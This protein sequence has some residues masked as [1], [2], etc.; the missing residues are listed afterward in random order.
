M[1][2]FN[3][4]EKLS[5]FRRD[6][7]CESTNDRLSRKEI[8]SYGVTEF[9][10]ALLMGPMV[11][12][13][14]YV[15]QFVLSG[16]AEERTTFLAVFGVVFIFLKIQDGIT[17]ILFGTMVDGTR[18]RF[19]KCR[20]WA[21]FTPIPFGLMVIVCFLPIHL[22][23]AAAIVLGTI[24]YFV[25][26]LVYTV[27]DIGYWALSACVSTNQE[28]RTKIIRGARFYGAVGG[29][30]PNVLFM[31]I[32][33][34][35]RTLT[36]SEQLG[37]V[38]PAIIMVSIGVAITSATMGNVKERVKQPEKKENVIK[39]IGLLFQNKPLLVLLAVQVL[40]FVVG[41]GTAMNHYFNIWNYRETLKFNS[42]QLNFFGMQFSTEAIMG[43][44]INIL[45]VIPTILGFALAPKFIKKF[46]AKNIMVWGSVYIFVMGLIRFFF[47]G[48]IHIPAMLVFSFFTAVPGSF[49]SVAGTAMFS[50]TIE[51]L[52]LKTGHRAEGSTFSVLTFINK[53]G[54]GIQQGGVLVLLAIIG[55]KTQLEVNAEAGEQQPQAVLDAIFA[56]LCLSPAIAAAVSAVIYFFYR[57]DDKAHAEALRQIAERKAEKAK[58]AVEVASDVAENSAPQVVAPLATENVDDPPSAKRLINF[59]KLIAFGVA[60]LGLSVGIILLL[61][62]LSK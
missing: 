26:T 55:Y 49:M 54:T 32:K 29:L 45:G 24:A 20:P 42:F 50:N 57:F 27:N 22:P 14:Y 51:Y 46:G 44:F 15:S 41:I 8:F 25:Y 17:D 30:F 58:L 53:V 28:E 33:D 1:I 52:E 34:V 19:G 56:W 11:F 7:K 23:Y 60:I 3:I 31:P 61:A 62:N 6:W 59:Y 38:I 9:G 2:R 13:T 47:V 4:K 16:T 40:G 43:T 36:G 48:Y 37:Y 18:S 35:V 12:F 21:L 39:N 5:D 10:R